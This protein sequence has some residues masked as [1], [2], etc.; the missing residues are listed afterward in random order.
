MQGLPG[1]VRPRGREGCWGNPGSWG[2]PGAVSPPRPPLGWPHR[3]LS[4]RVLGQ[5]G[6]TCR[7]LESQRPLR[8][9][10]GLP[11]GLGL[12]FLRVHGPSRCLVHGTLRLPLV[13][14][15]ALGAGRPASRLL[16]AHVGPGHIPWATCLSPPSPQ[17]ASHPSGSLLRRPFLTRGRRSLRASAVCRPGLWVG[18][19]SHLSQ[20]RRAEG[21]Q[22]SGTCPSPPPVPA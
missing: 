6:A 17:A 9:A 8:W 11:S 4:T 5:T 21:H 13:D 18:G 16:C 2:F 7:A 20:S 10:R 15:E 19:R 22:G 3:R 1:T 12:P 14:A